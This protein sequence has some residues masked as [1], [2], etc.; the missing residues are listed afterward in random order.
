MEILHHAKIRDAEVVNFLNRVFGVSLLFLH[1]SANF[2]GLISSQSSP[3]KIHN[4]FS[5]LTAWR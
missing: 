4:R 2:H 5:E 1:I 3:F